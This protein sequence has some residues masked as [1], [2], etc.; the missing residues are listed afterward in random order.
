M[1]RETWYWNMRAKENGIKLIEYLSKFTRKQRNMKKTTLDIKDNSDITI[2]LQEKINESNSLIFIP[3]GSYTISASI[4]LKSN[5]HISGASNH[6]TKLFFAKATNSNMFTN[7]DHSNG[8][9]NILVSDLWLDGN[10]SQQFRPENEKALS[11]CNIFKF[12]RS[13]NIKLLNI[14][15]SNCKQTAMHFNQCNGVLIDNLQALSMGW[16]G[17]STS[18]TDDIQ[19]SNVYIYDSGKDIMHSAVHYDGGIG[20]YF[21]G[22]IEKCTGNGIMLDSKYSVFNKSVIQANCVDCK[23][24]VSLSG[25]H[26]NQLSNVLIQNTKTLNCEVGI[27]VSNSKDVFITGCDIQKS[28]QHGILLQGKYGGCDTVVI[29]TTFDNKLDI[30]EVHSSKDNYF[31]RNNVGIQSKVE[32]NKEVEN[33]NLSVSNEDYLDKYNDSCSVCGSK[34]DFIYHGKSVRESY[35]C[36]AC[37]AS[38]RHRGQAKA[39]IDTYGDSTTKSI[40][41]LSQQDSFKKI[42]IFEPGIIGPLRKYFSSFPN[43]SQSYFWDDLPLG[44]TR[45]G[46]Q[47]QNLEC[48][49]FK[50]NSIDLLITADIFEHI[51][52]PWD[53]FTDIQRVLKVGGKHIFTIPVQY[54]LP[55]KT[56]YRVDTSTSEDIHV[57]PE[58]YHIAGDGG[59]SLVYTDF[60]GDMLE[61][62]NAIGLKTEY[63]FI[64]DSNEFRKKNIT[65]ISTKE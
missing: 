12:I 36:Q 18:G 21:S 38:L 37:K 31:I 32:L 14:K 49:T 27:M 43:Y 6:A 25:D 19:A 52:K 10:S 51:R 55:K 44:E 29:D 41:E 4:Q 9:D 58:R 45:D 23:R 15:A 42:T 28:S 24:A 60:G 2:L 8:N 13:S 53:A 54:P 16:S 47:N 22:V 64:D 5:T 26:N 63:V 11:F 35:R 56:I 46:I 59:K 40:K 50:D 1:Y 30:S 62:L 65:F 34:S 39:I 48:L 17:I 7:S 3:E 57:L 20:S 33:K 61:K